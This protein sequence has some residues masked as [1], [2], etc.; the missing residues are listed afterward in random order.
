LRVDQKKQLLFQTSLYLQD[1]RSRGQPR[2][3]SYSYGTGIFLVKKNRPVGVRTLREL[4]R[5]IRA[6]NR[7]NKIQAVVLHLIKRLPKPLEGSGYHVYLDNLFI[8]TRFVQ[9]ARSQGVAI[10]RTCRTTSGVIKELLDLQKSDK[11]DVIP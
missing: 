8:S 3:G 7:G 11:K 2:G 6:R 10:T 9:Y 4:G 5:T 1:I